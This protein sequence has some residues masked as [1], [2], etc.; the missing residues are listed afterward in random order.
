MRN[1]IIVSVVGGIAILA[2]LLY[3]LQSHHLFP[4][5]VSQPIVISDSSVDVKLDG[6]LNLV[7]DNKHHRIKN[8]QVHHIAMTDG[9]GKTLTLCTGK[10][11]VGT[12]TSYQKKDVVGTYSFDIS[13]PNRSDTDLGSHDWNDFTPSGAVNQLTLN[14][15]LVDKNG[16]PCRH[17][18]Y[19]ICFDE[20]C[21]VTTK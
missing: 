12:I 7:L 16:T 13:E 19:T 5:V 18:K 4:F 2:G 15:G 17:C 20:A 10:S 21:K 9:G 3:Y 11:C 6:P 1:R 14:G 8:H